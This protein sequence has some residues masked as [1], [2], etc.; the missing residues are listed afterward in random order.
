MKRI[1][2]IIALVLALAVPSFAAG[3]IICASTTSTQNSGLFDHILPLFEKATGIEIHVVAVGTGAALEMGKRGDADV[4]LV[5]ARGLELRMVEEGWF[6]GRRDVMY[7][8]FVILGPTEDPAGVMSAAGVSEA[9]MRVAL[10]GSP[11]VSRGDNSGTHMRERALWRASPVPTPSGQ[12]YLEAGQGMSKTIRLAAEKRAYTLSDRGTWLSMAD[13]ADT[14]LAIVFEGDPP[15]FNQYGAMAVN[16]ERHPGVKY[17][18]AMR[19]VDWLASAEGQAAIGA[20]R[21]SHGH[22]LFTPNASRQARP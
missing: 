4:L 19:F 9:L 17:A 2:I 21:D 12:W 15:L 3:R 20:Y 14:G 8:D 7:N 22:Q 10:A 18:E 5:H 11:F 13:Q 6:V 1:A 16:P